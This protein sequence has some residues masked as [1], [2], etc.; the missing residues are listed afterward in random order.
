MLTM[1]FK[2]GILSLGI[3]Y[4]PQ[5][6]KKNN[7]IFSSPLLQH[8]NSAYLHNI[9]T[10]PLLLCCKTKK[11]THIYGPIFISKI[12]LYQRIPRKITPITNKMGD[13]TPFKKQTVRK[14]RAQEY[15]IT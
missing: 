4:F 13:K 10:C 5:A 14:M 8:K 2:F 7:S 15:A 11:A 12:T 9:F 1:P 3:I 6:H